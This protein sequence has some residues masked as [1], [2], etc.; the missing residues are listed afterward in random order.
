MNYGH[1][2]LQWKMTAR[3]EHWEMTKTETSKLQFDV[4]V[5]KSLPVCTELLGQ[6]KWWGFWTGYH[7][8]SRPPAVQQDLQM[9]HHTGRNSIPPPPSLSFQLPPSSQMPLVHFLNEGAG[10]EGFTKDQSGWHTKIC[11]W[12][13]SKK[14]D[15]YISVYAQTM[16]SKSVSPCQRH[17]YNTC[18]SKGFN[19][20]PSKIEEVCFTRADMGV[21]VL[22]LWPCII[23]SLLWWPET[24][25]QAPPSNSESDS[26]FS[27][28][29]D[30]FKISLW[31]S[32]LP[33]WP[34][35]AKCWTST[36]Q[37]WKENC[38]FHVLCPKFL[39]YS[40]ATTKSE[41]EVSSNCQEKHIIW[42]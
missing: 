4:K 20:E 8:V 25:Q 24:D 15:F 6:G 13:H 2:Q 34:K 33:S 31:H 5:G 40:I 32:R 7:W 14:I 18:I 3:A 17:N 26:L 21:D 36:T 39:L 10:V 35:C 37:R 30:K 28:K 41:S 29:A 38:F 42:V 16:S 1:I 9:T 12:K 23:H 11:E 19:Q 22:C 27:F